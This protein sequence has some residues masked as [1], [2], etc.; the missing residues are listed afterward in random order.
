MFTVLDED[1]FVL[2]NYERFT[3]IP[4]DY[5]VFILVGYNKSLDGKPIIEWCTSKNA[6]DEYDIYGYYKDVEI[7]NE[8][9]E[10]YLA[11]MEY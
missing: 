5:C 2:R 8:T 4:L 11:I 9:Y 10:R 1:R 3:D 6:D 7:D